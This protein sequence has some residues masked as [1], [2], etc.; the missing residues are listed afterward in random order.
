MS[1]LPVLNPSP[2]LFSLLSLSCSTTLVIFTVSGRIGIEPA[3]DASTP[4]CLLDDPSESFLICDPVCAH[5]RPTLTLINMKD[6]PDMAGPVSTAVNCK[7]EC[8]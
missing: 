5:P 1:K 7:L 2:T 6:M 4:L 8:A 3:E